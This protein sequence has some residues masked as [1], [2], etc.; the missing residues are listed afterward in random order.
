LGRESFAR[1]EATHHSRQEVRRSS[2]AYRDVKGVVHI[3]QEAGIARVVAQLR[4]L[5]AIKG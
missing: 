4:P 1:R 5:G 2:D 3:L